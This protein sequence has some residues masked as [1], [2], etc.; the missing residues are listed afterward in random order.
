MSKNKDANKPEV[1]D[2]KEYIISV[3]RVSKVVKGG[4]NFS[5]AV[6]LVKGNGKGE[7]S[8]G[9]GK[10]KEVMDAKKKAA[11]KTQY[12]K[13]RVNLK[14]SRTIHHD[15][16]GTFGAAKVI[17]RKAPPGTGIIAGGPVRSILDALGVH[18]V[19]SKSTGTSN[20]YNVV[21]ATFAALQKLS[22]PK[23]IAEKR[24]LAIADLID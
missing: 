12:S 1:T 21:Y 6:L 11:S 23:Q 7:V 18:D 14:D 16:V 8:Y 4:T 3:N 19:V 10:A 24:G 13:M 17:L 5:F 9:H 22:S 20:P 15:V 2:G